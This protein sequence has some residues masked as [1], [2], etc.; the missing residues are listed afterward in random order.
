MGVVIIMSHHIFWKKIEQNLFF[1]HDL[2]P[3]DCFQHFLPYFGSASKFTSIGIF[4]IAKCNLPC[5]WFLW[6]CHESYIQEILT[7]CHRIIL[8]C[9][10]VIS[11]KFHAFPINPRKQVKFSINLWICRPFV[12][13]NRLLIKKISHKRLLFRSVVDGSHHAEQFDNCLQR[14]NAKNS[15]YMDCYALTKASVFPAKP[16]R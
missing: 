10:L 9:V 2:W 7:W 15:L 12:P 13:Q 14:Q 4:Y 6:C 8:V 5:Q 16:I 3:H 1:D 11:S